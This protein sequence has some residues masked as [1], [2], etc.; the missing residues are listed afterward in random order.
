[1][2]PDREPDEVATRISLLSLVD[3]TAL[4]IDIFPALESDK[5][6]PCIS[7]PIPEEIS[8]FPP[9]AP[10]PLLSEKDPPTPFASME[11]PDLISIDAPDNPELAPVE[12]EIS[13]AEDPVDEL[14]PVE[15]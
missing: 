8:T 15:I 13:P 10:E 2:E 12:I 3:V 14:S 11:S 5:S 4:S 6:P 9:T 7:K 1:M